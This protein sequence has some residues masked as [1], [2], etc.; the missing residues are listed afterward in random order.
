M[1]NL[2]KALQIA[3]QAHAG[4]QDKEGRPYITHQLRLMAAMADDEARIVAVL[5]DV[6]EDTATTLD[7][8]HR[9]GF[10]AAILEAVA[11]VTHRKE[12]PYAE[13]VIR[14]RGNSIARAVKL[15]DLTDNSR[16]DRCLLRPDRIER[17]FAR[18]HR[19]LLSYK[20]L[21]DGI[22]ESEYRTLMQK[23]GELT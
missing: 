10:S 13:Y 15:A 21:T 1:S 5:H 2:D 6:I 7:D 19:Y 11:L 4:Q 16:P 9:A 3:V 18:I 12:E 20:F 22:S 8:L 17:D 14:C 23:H